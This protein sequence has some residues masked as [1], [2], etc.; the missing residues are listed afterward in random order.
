[1]LGKRNNAKIEAI[2]SR[3]RKRRPAP[4]ASQTSD[5]KPPGLQSVKRTEN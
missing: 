1:M 4:K 3:G 5:G 2:K